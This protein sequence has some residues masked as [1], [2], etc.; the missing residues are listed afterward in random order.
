MQAYWAE[1]LVISA[2][3]ESMCAISRTVKSYAEEHQWGGPRLAMFLWEAKPVKLGYVLTVEC[4]CSYQGNCS[5]SI[6]QWRER[7]PFKM[8]PFALR[9]NKLSMFSWLEVYVLI[10]AKLQAENVLISKWN[11]RLMF[12]DAMFFGVRLYCTRHL[13]LWSPTKSCGQ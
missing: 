9:N 13:K 11:S 10:S 5:L 6:S 1:N 8:N 4:P 12:F 3:W 2:N 7:R